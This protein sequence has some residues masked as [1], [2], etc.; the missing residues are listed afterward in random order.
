MKRLLS[1]LLA[2]TLLMGLMPLAAL[3]EGVDMFLGACLPKSVQ[4]SSG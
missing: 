4:A 1:I 3:P 2:L